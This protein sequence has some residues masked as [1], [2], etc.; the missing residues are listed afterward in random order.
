MQSNASSDATAAAARRAQLRSSIE[1][2][3]ADMTFGVLSNHKQ[4]GGKTKGSD[5]KATKAATPSTSASLT[6][7]V[8]SS[9]RLQALVD[10]TQRL[11]QL[12]GEFE[13][14]EV[15]D[16][17]LATLQQTRVP[18]VPEEESAG[19]KKDA[20]GG[21][22]TASLLALRAW[23]ARKKFAE[24]CQLSLKPSSSP[25][26]P[27]TVGGG[28]GGGGAAAAAAA[29]ASSSSF[30][31][32]AKA[33]FLSFG[34]KGALRPRAADPKQR[35]AALKPLSNLSAAFKELEKCKGFHY[36]QQLQEAAVTGKGPS[37]ERGSGEAA[38][39]VSAT[40]FQVK[41][42]PAVVKRMSEVLTDLKQRWVQPP[43]ASAA[44]GAMPSMLPPEDAQKLFQTLASWPQP[45]LRLM[46]ETLQGPTLESTTEALRERVRRATFDVEE[47]THEQ[48]Q[49]VT[50]G[51]MHKSED[52]YFHQTELL[53][54]M[55][56]LFDQL[57]AAMQS[58]QST[59]VEK[60]REQ[61]RSVQRQFNT[62]YQ[63]TLRKEEAK[64]KRAKADLE[65][66]AAQRERL[67]GA[68]ADRQA[69]L[70][71]YVQEWQRLFDGNV[72]QQQ[73]CL[74]AMEQLENRLKEL[75][76]EQHF[77]VD[78]RIRKLADERQHKEAA[79]AFD[80]FANAHETA[81]QNT[82]QELAVLVDGVK[83]VGAAVEFSCGRFDAYLR[84][85]LLEHDKQELLEVRKQR[86][87]QFR[88]LYLTLGDLQFKKS[89]HAEEIAKKVEYYN[90]QQEIAMDALNPKAKEFSQARQKWQLVEQEVQSQLRNIEAR[91]QK[92]L[93]EFRPTERLL[94]EAGVHFTHPSE[95]LQQRN[96]V[97]QQKL[98]EYK[99]LMDNT[100][101]ANSR[102]G[103]GGAAGDANASS[104]SLSHSKTMKSGG[105]ENGGGAAAAATAAMGSDMRT[106]AD[107]LA[108][109]M[110]MFARQAPRLQSTEEGERH[111]FLPVSKKSSGVGAAAGSSSTKTT[112]SK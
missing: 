23:N 11:K 112:R 88:S 54:S 84:D 36:Q 5:D 87:E 100:V 19:G 61:L 20:K 12:L 8:P 89:R 57:E 38:T 14:L 18:V 109:D 55:N 66:L 79:A 103:G 111:S 70:M 51:D 52:L 83:Q 75:A 13:S 2:L 22:T 15:G 69:G 30:A 45:L 3:A 28:G 64:Q 16:Q 110:R 76:R 41:H 81:L 74:N 59:Q 26:S 21:A 68:R 60:P 98:L 46:N 6:T 94:I 63:E 56:P 58:H 48:E 93:E 86:L 35:E 29:A 50:D 104:S 37:N 108:E 72:R 82:A 73:E 105:R 65:R 78:D 102:G 49:A 34:E 53:E 95:E 44:A 10:S 67:K 39:G 1:D 96:A 107:I 31:A 91:S 32:E 24:L 33:A 4:I 80:F 99:Q 25:S 92:Q 43:T 90:L 71:L 27:V 106:A 77:L 9:A 17:G 101:S 7:Y 40:A 47:L 42:L 85:V 62:L 97:R